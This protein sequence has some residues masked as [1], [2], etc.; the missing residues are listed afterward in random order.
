MEK[1]ALEEETRGH[2]THL[3][4]LGGRADGYFNQ[5]FLKDKYQALEILFHEGF[6]RR[7]DLKKNK[8]HELIEESAAKVVG[9]EASLS[10]FKEFGDESDCHIAEKNI[11]ST[12]KYT[13]QFKQQLKQRKE[14]LAAGKSCPTIHPYN[15]A[16]IYG[17]HPYYGH[18][19]L[20]HY[21]FKRMG[22]FRG[23]VD[24]MSG[25]PTDF[26]E[27]RKILK[28]IRKY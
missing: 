5:N 6:H 24:L 27:S 19:N 17:E 3:F 2:N 25:L 4:Q 10:F 8:I 22:T 26:E 21:V 12:V 16:R 20:C 11:Q 14:E 28:A 18:F 23:F 13:T 1:R 7:R 9:L 15:N